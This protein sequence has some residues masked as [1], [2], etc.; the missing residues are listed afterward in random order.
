[1]GGNSPLKAPLE[2]DSQPEPKPERN[3]E[4]ADRPR[5]CCRSPEGSITGVAQPARNSWHAATTTTAVATIVCC[6]A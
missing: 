2:G 5:A 1:M 6:G 4:L 3:N